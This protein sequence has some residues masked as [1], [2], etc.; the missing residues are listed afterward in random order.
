[1]KRHFN[2]ILLPSLFCTDF[3]FIL[4]RPRSLNIFDKHLG[5]IILD[6]FE[7][8]HMSLC[9][10]SK[11]L[12]LGSSAL[13]ILLSFRATQRCFY[14]QSNGA[15]SS[16]YFLSSR[17]LSRSFVRHA[18][19]RR[20]T[21]RS[22][23]A[24]N[25]LANRGTSSR[26]SCNLGVLRQLAAARSPQAATGTE[27]AGGGDARRATPKRIDKSR[28]SRLPRRPIQE[29]QGP[30][31]AQAINIHR[32]ATLLRGLAHARDEEMMRARAHLVTLARN[33]HEITSKNQ[34]H[35]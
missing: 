11:S 25:R 12:H 28:Q 8:E 34:R 23:L 21:D 6:H 2:S 15:I 14:R 3:Q 18:S 19:G 27:G 33:S 30:R 29:G 1:M 5:Q 31:P 4:S 9:K 22:S 17:S 16:K 35:V 26:H 32:A 10:I 7:L 20:Q 24:T 13:T